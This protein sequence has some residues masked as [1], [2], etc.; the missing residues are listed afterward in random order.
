[1]GFFFYL[2]SNHIVLLYFVYVCYNLQHHK[3]KRFHTYMNCTCM[4]VLDFYNE[5]K[6]IIFMPRKSIVVFV[7]SFFLNSAF[8]TSEFIYMLFSIFVL[9]KFAEITTMNSFMQNSAFYECYY[10]RNII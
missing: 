9:F 3:I 7:F 4:R 8:A 10:N 2:N 5:M 6:R 1:M